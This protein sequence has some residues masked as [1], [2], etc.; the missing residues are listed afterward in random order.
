MLTEAKQKVQELVA[1]FKAARADGKVE[2]SEAIQLV[3]HAA[4]GV[5]AV[6][7]TFTAPGVDKKAAAKAALAEVIDLVVAWDIPQVPNI[8]EKTV[9]DPVLRMVLTYLADA[10]IEFSVSK[11]KSQP[12]GA[13]A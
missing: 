13:A 10:A 4:D 9:V 6:L 3:M 8:A 11:L 7:H 12:T 1:E 5:V 2:L